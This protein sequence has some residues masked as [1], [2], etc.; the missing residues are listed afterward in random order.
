M[1]ITLSIIF[2]STLIAS[3]T[4]LILN[5][6]ESNKT[7]LL[8]DEQDLIIIDMQ[9]MNESFLSDLNNELK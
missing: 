4:L 6:K 2:I 8:L 1:L 5:Y 9:T 3:I 7:L